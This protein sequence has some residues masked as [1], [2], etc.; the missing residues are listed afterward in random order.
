M[1]DIQRS[2]FLHSLCIVLLV[3]SITS[4]CYRMRQSEKIRRRRRRKTMTNYMHRRNT[5]C[6]QHTTHIHHYIINIILQSYSTYYIENRFSS[7]THSIF[8]LPLK[9]RLLYAVHIS[10]NSE[11]H[12]NFKR[13]HRAHATACLALN[14]L[15]CV[16]KYL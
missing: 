13:P 6:N 5:T 9:C 4:S 2:D 1:C 12:S 3:S 15:Q 7:L 8:A 11:T 10:I 14:I 16:I